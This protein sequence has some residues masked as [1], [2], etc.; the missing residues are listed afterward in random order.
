MQKDL[1]INAFIKALAPQGLQYHGQLQAPAELANVLVELQRAE[2][3]FSPLARGLCRGWYPVPS[4]PGRWYRQER[5][6]LRWLL[7]LHLDIFPAQ[8]KKCKPTTLF[9]H[10][11]NI[12][13]AQ[14]F[15]HLPGELLRSFRHWTQRSRKWQQQ[16]SSSF[17]YSV[18]CLGSP[19]QADERVKTVTWEGLYLLPQI[20]EAVGRRGSA[21]KTSKEPFSRSKWPLISSQDHISHLSGSMAVPGHAFWALQHPGPLSHG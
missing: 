1:A 21:P 9:Q 5:H 16:E 12:G 18:G 11:F 10:W 8:D 15:H 14:P 4:P 7:D 13:D 17:S 2:M 6:Q 3:I 20:E 19:A